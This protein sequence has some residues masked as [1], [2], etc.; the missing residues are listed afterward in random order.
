M[1][2]KLR[3]AK[4]K[5]ALKTL[6]ELEDLEEET[7]DEETAPEEDAMVNETGHILIDYIQL[8]QQVAAVELNK[9]TAVR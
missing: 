3:L 5:E 9:D 8:Q 1:E 7:E 4:G 2:N 6:K